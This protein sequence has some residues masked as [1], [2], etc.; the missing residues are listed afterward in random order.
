M[1]WWETSLE[2]RDQA[3]VLIIMDQ[4]K[5]TDPLNALTC[6]VCKNIL[7]NLYWEGA[8]IAEVC[9]FVV[10]IIPPPPTVPPRP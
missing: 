6:Y 4:T 8:D 5:I 9:C 7:R 3:E 1:F 10:D 2:I